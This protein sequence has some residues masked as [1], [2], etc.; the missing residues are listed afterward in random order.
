MDRE[1][2]RA[3]FE[4]AR[5]IAPSVEGLLDLA[6]VYHLLGDVGAEVSTCEAATRL[7]RESAVA[8][9]RYA[10]ALARTD[11]RGDCIAA[12]D[13]ALALADDAEVR[14]LREAVLASEPVGITRIAAA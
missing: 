13:R 9:S 1:A 11:R 4:R 8:W 7:D 6:L 12:C 5:A 2:A 10:H 14:E 3:A